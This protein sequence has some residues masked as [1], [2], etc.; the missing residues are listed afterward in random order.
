MEFCP[1]FGTVVPS[2][3]N[4]NR[5]G[6]GS[7]S[8]YAASKNSTGKSWASPPGRKRYCRHPLY[9]SHHVRLVKEHEKP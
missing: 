9:F 7:L 4:E 6:W 1:G 2:P 5:E 3:P 8:I